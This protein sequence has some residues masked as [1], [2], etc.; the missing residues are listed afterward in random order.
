MV[1]NAV[2]K[3]GIVNP[4]VEAN[5]VSAV[6]KSAAKTEDISEL[7]AGNTNKITDSTVKENKSISKGLLLGALVV[8]DAAI[9]R[10]PLGKFLANIMHKSSVKTLKSSYVMHLK[11]YKANRWN[12]LDVKPHLGKS[13]DDLRAWAKE[14]GIAKI[15]IKDFNGHDDIKKFQKVLESLTSAYNKSKGRLIMPRKITLLNMGGT[16][17]DANVTVSGAVEINKLYSG[18]QLA[19]SI[20]HELG[21][22]NH[23]SR[24][25]A[26]GDF[27]LDKTLN[28]AQQMQIRPILGDYAITD[29]SEFVAEAFAAMMRGEKLPPEIMRLYARYKGPSVHFLKA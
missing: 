13:M 12:F 8:A 21:H 26:K 20:M 29:S 3:N 18:E 5:K 23:H 22:I 27:D 7:L 15:N 2:E 24:I 6:Q 17:V 14:L 4:V 28:F 19:D 1:T 16:R 25:L 11:K 10:K 9:F